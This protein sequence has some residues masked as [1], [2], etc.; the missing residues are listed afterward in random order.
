HAL[1]IAD[2]LRDNKKYEDAWNIYHEL[3]KD[4]KVKLTALIN[5]A[6]CYKELSHKEDIAFT[7]ALELYSNKKYKESFDIFC[8]LSLSKKNCYIKTQDLFF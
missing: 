1:R 6:D 5:M 8:K 7:T 3:T 4:D 2:Q